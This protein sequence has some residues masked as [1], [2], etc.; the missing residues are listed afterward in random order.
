MRRMCLKIF[1]MA[2]LLAPVC[3]SPGWADEPD[4]YPFR[5]VSIGPKF[6][7]FRPDSGGDWTGSAG[8]QIRI[9]MTPTWA[10]EG[11]ATYRRRRFAPSTRVDTYPGPAAGIAYLFPNPLHISPYI[12]AGAGWYFTHVDAATGDSTTNRFGPHLGG[13]LQLFLNRKWSVDA[14]YRHFWIEDI[15]TPGSVL[16]QD[17]HD[18]GHQVSAALNYHF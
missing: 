9:H 1:A 15:H 14:D 18:D 4:V 8:A 16:N 2:A 12:L 7:L 13:G 10:L 11:A 5:R 6:N 3:G 17:L